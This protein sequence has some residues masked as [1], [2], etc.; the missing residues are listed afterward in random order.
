MR[1]PALARRLVPALMLA[2]LAGAPAPAG[3]AETRCAPETGLSWARVQVFAEAGCRGGQMVIRADDG[4][5]DRPNFT[6]FRNFDGRT[7]DVDNSRSSLII[8]AGTCVRLFDAVDYGGDA[9]TNICATSGRLD[10]NLSRFDNRTTSMRVCTTR[11]PDACAPGGGPAPAGDRPPAPAGAPPA[12][13]AAPAVPAVPA[14]P[15]LARGSRYV[16]LGDSYSSGLGTRDYAFD[17]ACKR[18]P[19]AYPARVDL[20]LDTVMTFRACAGARTGDVLSTQARSLSRSTRLVTI[21]IGGNDAGFS[22]IVTQCAKP[23]PTTCWGDITN[24]E[25]FAREELPGRLDAVYDDIRRRAPRALVV[26]ANYPRIFSEGGECSI[27]RISRG[28]QRRLNAATDLLTGVIRREIRG[29]SNFRFADVRDAFAAHSVCDDGAWLNGASW[30]KEESYHPN[31]E[32]NR[33]Y[34]DAV[35]AAIRR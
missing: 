14:A 1:V 8:A 4:A 16:A 33:A 5:P 27:A 28:E 12:P 18:G 9:S 19:R 13:T 2:G 31:V 25:R 34:A 26:V 23:W 24:A 17:D 35:L 3:A 32:G 6:A 30:P 20:A 10:W 7:Y 22:G 15:R 21:T 29:R 11:A